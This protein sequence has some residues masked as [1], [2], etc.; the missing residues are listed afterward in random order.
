MD[1]LA[2]PN[3]LPLHTLHGA[4]VKMV[5]CKIVKREYARWLRQELLRELR[6]VVSELPA[7]W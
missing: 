3:A 1:T 2:Y 6:G 7:D 5:K 4:R